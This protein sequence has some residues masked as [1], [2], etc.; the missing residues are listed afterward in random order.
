MRKHR[1]FHMLLYYWK[2]VNEGPPSFPYISEIKAII[3]TALSS[4]TEK[5]ALTLRRDRPNAGALRGTPCNLASE[6]CQTFCWWEPKDESHQSHR[7]KCTCKSANDESQK[8]R[9]WTTE[10]A[11]I[12]LALYRFMGSL[13]LN[14]DPVPKVKGHWHSDT[15][16]SKL[17]VATGSHIFKIT[18][19]SIHVCTVHVFKKKQQKVHR[20]A[21]LWLN[22]SV[23][24]VSA[25]VITAEDSVGRRWSS[26]AI[27]ATL[28]RS[29][30]LSHGAMDRWG[31][32]PGNHTVSNTCDANQTTLTKPCV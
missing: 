8:L 9:S 6:F 20:S 26:L 29:F 16:Y 15:V 13:F 3:V 7:R 19:L 4:S 18:S 31:R 22:S 12:L 5:G 32:S 2:Y 21:P 23:S 1:E 27:P 14:S 11:F 30:A 17:K 28:C 24:S 25:D 10:H